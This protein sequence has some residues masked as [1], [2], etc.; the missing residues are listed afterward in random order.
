[1]ADRLTPLCGCSVVCWHLQPDSHSLS[2]SVTQPCNEITLHV[3]IKTQNK[4]HKVDNVCTDTPTPVL[5]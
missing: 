4:T 3:W 1:M 5:L 2:H